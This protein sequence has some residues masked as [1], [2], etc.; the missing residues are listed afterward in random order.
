M[1]ILYTDASYRW[2]DTERNNSPVCNGK[3]CVADGEGFVLVEQAGVGKVPKLK[4]YINIFELIA[5]ARA[6][7]VAIEKGWIG[8]LS[9][10]SDSQIAVIWASSKK[11]NPKIETVAH[12]NALDYLRSALK[13]Y[14]GIVT[15]RHTPRENNPAGHVLE[16]KKYSK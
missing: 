7:E 1:K 10:Y 16:E 6:V 9:I 3:I 8:S 12:V 13:N 15:F 4:Q 2:Q 5:I 14:G 11:V